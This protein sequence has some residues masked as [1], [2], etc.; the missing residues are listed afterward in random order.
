MSIARSSFL[1]SAGTLLSRVSGVLRESVN[2]AAFG[3]SVYMDAFVVAFRIPNLLRD[4]LAE[5]AL[6]SSFTKVYSSVSVEDPEAAE[7]LLIHTLQL[8]TLISLCVTAL[9]MIFA[10]QLVDLMTAAKT[11]AEADVFRSTTIGLTQLMFPFIGFAAFGA[12][13]QGALYQRGG[14]FLAAVAPILFNLGSIVGALWIGNVANHILPA[15]WVTYFGNASIFGLAFGTLLGGAAQSGIQLCGIWRPL[16]KGRS[17]WP[18]KFPWS[19]HVK[20]VFFLM[21][22]M[23]IA[24]SSG[25]INA[26]VNTNF[27]TSLGAGAVTWLNFAFRLVQLPIGMFGV[28]VGA[29]VLP[30]LSKSITE[31][32]GR[33][34]A[35]SSREAINALDLVCW[36]MIPCMVFMFG[37][38]LDITRLIYEAGRFSAGDTAATAAAIQAYSCGLLS[39]GLLKVLNSYYYAIDRTRF[40]MIV[41]FFS[42]ICNYI[43]NSMLVQK[44]GHEGLAMTASLTLTMNA[45]LLII[46]MSRDGI[47]V[48][49]KQIFTSIGL[50]LL[51]TAIISFMRHWYAPELAGFSFNRITA[52]FSSTTTHKLDAT[53]RLIFDGFVVVGVF[54]AV[55]LARIRKTPR[56]AFAMLKRRSTG[57]KL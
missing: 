32:G 55:G 28:A 8:V 31:A 40:P 11:T 12:V 9:G 44:F 15:S 2:G 19:P 41:S 5:G 38:A 35:K 3:A 24:A 30:A 18:K 16:L 10:P 52:I 33:V 22:P 56:A 48:D 27:A 45:L 53:I 25:Q 14:F 23:V 46:G 43:A 50:L 13:V 57:K 42:I 20:K 54:S 37:S 39:Y 34:D 17:L 36:L 7:K 4:L 26:M 49:K 1:F 6:G 47:Q 29:A 21:T 51:A